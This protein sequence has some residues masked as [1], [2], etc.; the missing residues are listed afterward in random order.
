MRAP[1][2]ARVHPAH[3][4]AGAVGGAERADPCVLL[5]HS[6]P[7][8][9]I[10]FCAASSVNPC[11]SDMRDSPSVCDA[12]RQYANARYMEDALCSL[13]KGNNVAVEA[14]PGAGKSWLLLEANRD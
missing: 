4:R 14:V 9:E 13:E 7:P 2:H 10:A 12:N 8:P 5:R 1:P 3:H 11:L 6:M